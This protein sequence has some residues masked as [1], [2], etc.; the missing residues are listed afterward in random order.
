MQIELADVEKAFLFKKN[1]MSEKK[2]Q[3]EDK[4]LEKVTSTEYK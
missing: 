1:D 2:K 3:S 4:L